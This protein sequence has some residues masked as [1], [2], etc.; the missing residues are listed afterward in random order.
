MS[1]TY[2]PQA[3]AAYTRL[4]DQPSVETREVSDVCILDVDGSGNLVAI[5]LL[6]VFG[7][8]GASL[9]ELS[10]QGLIDSTLLHRIMSELRSELLAA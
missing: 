9:H 4:S 3:D 6:S 1:L 10:K 2:D 5:E 8:A 7:F